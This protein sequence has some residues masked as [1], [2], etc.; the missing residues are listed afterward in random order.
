MYC[1][2]RLSSGG[3]DYQIVFLVSGLVALCD[4]V[5]C[6]SSLMNLP[7]SVNLATGSVL[8]L[9]QPHHLMLNHSASSMT[10]SAIRW[11]LP[12]VAMTSETNVRA[13]NARTPSTT[14]RNVGC[15]DDPGASMLDRKLSLSSWATVSGSMNRWRW[16]W[17]FPAARLVFN[18]KL[19]LQ[20]RNW[21]G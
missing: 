7:S 11:T 4:G 3:W 17:L 18:L 8:I 1:T 15:R 9:F 12:P 19:G 21:R 10:R 2:K 20:Y 13:S 5:V 6:C 14:S 16:R